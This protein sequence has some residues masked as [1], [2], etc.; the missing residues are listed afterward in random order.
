MT[1]A[2]YHLRGEGLELKWK[3]PVRVGNVRI[4]LQSAKVPD[5]LRARDL[6]LLLTM[7][8]E[9]R[10]VMG[11]EDKGKPEGTP[12]KGPPDSPGQPGKPPHQPPGPPHEPPGPPSP[13]R[14]PKRRDV[15]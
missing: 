7:G 10:K 8:G 15:G 5:T 12:G 13:P 3:G 14:P 9:R 4:C 6:A 2:V 11:K 1:P